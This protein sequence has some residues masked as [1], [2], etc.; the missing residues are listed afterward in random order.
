MLY[1]VMNDCNNIIRSLAECNASK[2]SRSVDLCLTSYV[3]QLAMQYLRN[4]E[5]NRDAICK[6]QSAPK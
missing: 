1:E 3:A 4:A 5:V 6:L 2:S